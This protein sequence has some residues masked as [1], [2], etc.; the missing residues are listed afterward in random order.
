MDILD[1][2]RHLQEE[3]NWSVYHL[4]L[5]S[6]ITQSTLNNMFKRGTD[7]SIRTLSALCEAFGITLADFFSEEGRTEISQ[8]ERALLM[9]YRKLSS[10]E[11]AAVSNLVH[12]LLK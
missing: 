1:R 6:G 3:R 9:E 2:I 5:E 12:E 11:K 4:S 10:K 8:S 7:P